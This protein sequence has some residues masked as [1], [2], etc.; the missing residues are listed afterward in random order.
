MYLIQVHRIHPANTDMF[1]TTE[2]NLWTLFKLQTHQKSYCVYYFFF[3]III[4]TGQV[5]LNPIE[6]ISER[7]FSDKQYPTQGNWANVRYAT[8]AEKERAMA[9]SGR[10]VLP[11]IMVG[12]VECRE[13]PRMNLASAGI[14]SPERYRHW[15]FVL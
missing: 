10:Q 13:V 15:F 12:V 4:T 3:Y 1:I 7:L 5:I 9:L 14:T 2:P 6:N 8:R 11:G